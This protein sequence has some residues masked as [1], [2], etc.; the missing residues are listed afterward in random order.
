MMGVGKSTVGRLVAERRGVPF[1]DLDD[2]VAETAGRS[3]PEVFTAEGE[4]GFRRRESAALTAVAGAAAVVACG[5]GAV[6]VAGNV[7]RLRASGMVVWLVAPAEV[8]E[9]R[10]GGGAGRPLLAGDEVGRGLR[11]LGEARAA[12]YAAA[13][14]HRV[15]TAGRA[16]E[17]VATEVVRRWNEWT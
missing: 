10:V 9:E 7:E 11:R 1:V 14:H 2:E 5:G 15:G 12:A 4:V 6:V 3:I 13:A 17:E 8:L 16:P